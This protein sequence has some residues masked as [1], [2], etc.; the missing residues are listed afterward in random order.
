MK[1]NHTDVTSTPAPQLAAIIFRGFFALL[2]PSLL[3]SVLAGAC[4]A[5]AMRVFRLLGG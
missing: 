2:L 4:A 3:F 5:I 1:F